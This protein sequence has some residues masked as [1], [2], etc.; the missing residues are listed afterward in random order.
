MIRITS[1][2]TKTAPPAPQFAGALRGLRPL[3]PLRGVVLLA[4]LAATAVAAQ[5]GVLPF[6][7]VA[8]GQSQIVEV[9]NPTG[10]VVRVSTLAP[11]SGTF[12]SLTYSSGEVLNLATG[13]GIGT[14]R[15]LLAGG[16]ELFG[17]FTVQLLPGADPSL[18]DLLGQMVFS[19]GTGGFLG[20]SGTA[21]FQGRGQFVS[22]SLALTHFEFRGTVST[23]PEPA[24]ALL[25][26]LGLVACG[27]RQCRQHQPVP[28]SAPTPAP[29]AAYQLA[30]RSGVAPMR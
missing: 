19:G 12:G 22:A 21:A 14:N 1:L 7:A 2:A 30:S 20:A 28:G 18:F 9:L 10:P 27:W 26:A 23:V 8:D 11:G 17:S 13:Q 16:D 5:A 24:T 6:N 15:F 25:V 29:D 3:R 4:C